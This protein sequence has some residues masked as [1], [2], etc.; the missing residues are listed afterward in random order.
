M[1]PGIENMQQLLDAMSQW[2]TNGR[3]P[4]SDMP[5]MPQMPQQNQDPRMQ[6]LMQQMQQMQS[7]HSN[8]TQNIQ[9][10]TQQNTI[11]KTKLDAETMR[12]S[13]KDKAMSKMPQ[14]LTYNGDNVSIDWNLFFA[15]NLPGWDDE[16]SYPLLK[17]VVE[18]MTNA[19]H[20]SSS[21]N[22]GQHGWSGQH[23]GQHS[24][25]QRHQ[26]GGQQP[27]T[28]EGQ[29]PYTPPSEPMIQPPT[30]PQADPSGLDWLYKKWGPTPNYYY[31]AGGFPGTMGGLK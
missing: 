4:S 22:D 11:D 19:G 21:Y 7:N 9:Q 28:N 17:N 10:Q 1:M 31:P 3:P 30:Q 29:P 20:G 13:I 24:G 5:Q 18:Q 26:Q 15:S 2:G 25:H 12:Q 23:D 6:A 27:P 8:A 16:G 14:W